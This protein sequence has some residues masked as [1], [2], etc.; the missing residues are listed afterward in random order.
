MKRKDLS[1]LLDQGIHTNY[2]CLVRRSKNNK[3]IYSKD[4]FYNVHNKE[5][6]EIKSFTSIH[7]A[8]KEQNN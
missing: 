5:T 2:G 1:Y 7:E 4:Q 8:L 3:T 6:K